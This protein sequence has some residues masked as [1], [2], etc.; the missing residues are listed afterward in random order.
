MGFNHILCPNLRETVSQKASGRR[1]VDI[2][3]FDCSRNVDHLQLNW[4]FQ[5]VPK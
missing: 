5:N 2:H 4:H 3:L 1:L